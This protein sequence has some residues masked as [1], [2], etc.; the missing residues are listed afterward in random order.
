MIDKKLEPWY[1]IMF[2]IFLGF[3]AI[4][5]LHNMYDLPR[6]IVVTNDI[7]DTSRGQ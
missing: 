4:L 1:D 3:I 2:S 6:T 7:K 5:L